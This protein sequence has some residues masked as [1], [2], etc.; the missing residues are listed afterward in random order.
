MAKLG[1]EIALTEIELEVLGIFVRRKIMGDMA[2]A[3]LLD[4]LVL[5]LVENSEHELSNG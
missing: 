3:G 5:K 4:Q 2:I 1:K